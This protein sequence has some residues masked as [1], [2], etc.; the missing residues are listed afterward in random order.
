MVTGQWYGLIMQD[1][2]VSGNTIRH[3]ARVNSTMLMGT[4]MM[5]SG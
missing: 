3:V 5:E 2:K 1:M 4:Y